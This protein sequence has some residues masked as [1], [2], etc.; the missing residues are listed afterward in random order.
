MPVTVAIPA[1]GLIDSTLPPEPKTSGMITEKPAP[2]AANPGNDQP[3]DCTDKAHTSPPAATRL[4][5]RTVSMGPRRAVM[6][7]PRKRKIAMDAEK[8]AYPVAAVPAPACSTCFRY[9]A[10]QS[11]IAPSES[12]QQ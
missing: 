10:V 1:P 8:T 3:G 2:V 7:S 5:V 4:P 11:A 6:I 9:T 12:K